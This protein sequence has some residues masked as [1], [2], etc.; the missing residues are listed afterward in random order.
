[1]KLHWSPRSPFVRKVMIVLHETTLLDQVECVRTVVAF[2][3]PPEDNILRDNPL[4]KIPAL[5][6]DDG[7]CLFDSR[8]IC[9]YLDTLHDRAPLLPAS[10]PPRFAHL[11]WQ[12]LCDGITDI[13]LHLRLEVMREASNEVVLEGYR[14]KL[15]ASLSTLEKEAADLA[16]APF[17]LGHIS[18]IAMLGQ[19]DLRYAQS[20]W[21][22]AFQNLARWEATMS[23][24]PSVRATAIVDDAPPASGE[25]HDFIDFTKTV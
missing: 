23:E 25:P 15:A 20:N 18:A 17:G 9:E 22:G 19:L 5:V 8:V 24:R 1:M 13:L 10:G 14:R 7:I 21:R 16:E 11:R 12:A 2:L 3:Q 4:G 6:L